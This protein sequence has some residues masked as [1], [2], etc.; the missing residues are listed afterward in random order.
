MKLAK[1]NPWSVL[2]VTCLAVFAVYLD[3][4]LLFVAFPAIKATFR[5]VSEAQLSWVLNAYTVVFG[6]ILVPAGRLADRMALGLLPQRTRWG[7]GG[8]RWAPAAD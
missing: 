3:T 2:A 6:A 5:A 8:R 1:G 7:R 4:T